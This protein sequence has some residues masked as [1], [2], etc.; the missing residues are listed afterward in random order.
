MKV[1][2]DA[3]ALETGADSRNAGVA[4]VAAMIVPALA[5]AAPQHEFHVWV[6]PRVEPPAAWSDIPNLKVHRIWRRYRT[7]W[8]VGETF[9]ATRAKVDC[10]LSLANRIPKRLPVPKVLIMHDIF[11][12]QYPEMFNAEDLKYYRREFAYSFAKCA[13]ILSVSES[14]KRAVVANYGYPPDKIS[15]I[16]LGPGNPVDRR[17]YASVSDAEL[18]EMGVQ[19]NRFI[20][21][22]STLE[23]RKNFPRLIEAMGLIAK[24][25]ELKEVGLVVAGGRGWKDGPIF[26]RVKELGLEDRITFLGFVPGEWLPALF[27]RSEAF[28]ASSLDEGFGIPALEAMMM[29]APIISSNGGSLPEVGGDLATYFDPRDVEDMAGAI[30]KFLL[31]GQDRENL[32]QRGFERAKMFS[33][34]RCAEIA[35]GALESVTGKR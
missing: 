14:T 10:W 29:G 35:V 9:E 5:K 7:W 30:T 8:L 24:N 6:L 26:D 3:L 17:P 11:P 19:F 33:W 28:V 15:V 18:K 16:P 1:G 31:A 23:P 25:E 12:I 27:G 13:H 21:A 20:F 32:I 34:E 22:L 4:R 2:I